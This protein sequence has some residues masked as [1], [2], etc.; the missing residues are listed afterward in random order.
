[1]II[2]GLSIAVVAFARHRVLDGRASVV[3]AEFN[4]LE[5]YLQERRRRRC[6]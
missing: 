2:I 6:Q 5:R 4:K 1:M 3:P